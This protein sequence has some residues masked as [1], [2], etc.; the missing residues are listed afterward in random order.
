M[1]IPAA[2]VVVGMA[3]LTLAI[4]TEDGLVADDYY[5]RGLAINRLIAREASARA[6]GVR[7]Q[8]WFEPGAGRVRIRLDGKVATGERVRLGFVHPTRAGLDRS[9]DLK[10][11]GAGL[12]E[13][14]LGPLA[15]GRWHV[16]LEDEHR[17]WRIVGELQR[18]GDTAAMLTPG[19]TD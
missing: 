10:R 16:T 18:P 8:L 5:K 13:G 4:R 3:M 12:Y 7:A 19:A 17:V 1:A 14:V 15:P 9:A 6:D 11:S 2:S